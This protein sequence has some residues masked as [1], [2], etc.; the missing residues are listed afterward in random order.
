MEI[1]FERRKKQLKSGCWQE[2][3]GAV[4]PGEVFRPS[5]KQKG[6]GMEDK[7]WVI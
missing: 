2:N 1:S 3:R 4:G 6:R 5:E 7:D